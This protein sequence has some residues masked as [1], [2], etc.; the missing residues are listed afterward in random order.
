M[1][2]L[3]VPIFCCNQLGILRVDLNNISLDD[4]NHDED[5]SETII[6]IRFLPW[7]ITFEKCKAIKKV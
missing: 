5:D 1:N 6:H 3:V 4:T 2:I 7:H